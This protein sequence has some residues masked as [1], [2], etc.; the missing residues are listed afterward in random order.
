MSLNIC[1]SVLLS[2]NPVI[3]ALCSSVILSSKPMFFCLIQKPHLVRRPLSVGEG[4]GE[5]SW[6]GF[7]PYHRS[8]LFFILLFFWLG[9][10]SF[11]PLL[12]IAF[13]LF[14]LNINI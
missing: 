7:L 6:G 12:I 2:K 4:L 11:L 9:G 5:A 13:P 3:T 14:P 1:L 8:S 10:K